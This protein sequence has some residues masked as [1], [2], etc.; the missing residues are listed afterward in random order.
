MADGLSWHVQRGERLKALEELSLILAQNIEDS[1][2]Q[3]VSAL[4]GR[5]QEVLR[6]IDEIKNEQPV[7]V[8]P[9]DEIEKKRAARK[10]NA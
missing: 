2:P 5:L 9:V 1:P 10:R 8:N 3:Y 7:G 6:E 4:G